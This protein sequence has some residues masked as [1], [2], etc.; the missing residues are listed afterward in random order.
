MEIRTLIED[1]ERRRNS[2]VLVLA[3]SH[4]EIDMAPALYNALSAL[5]PPDGARIS[6][7]DI[8][9][10]CRGGAVTAARR[11]ALMLRQ[12]CD[13]LAFIVPHYC[14]SAGAILVLCADEIIAGPV[15]IF[16]PVDPQLQAPVGHS[17]EGAS[18]VSAEDIRRLPQLC[19]DWFG[20]DDDEA[21]RNA[22]S[23]LAD[24]FFPA[25]LSAF[26]RS[27]QEVRE[28]CEELLSMHMG[29]DEGAIAR[30]I[31]YLLH[32]HHSH[33]FPLTGDDLQKIGLPVVADPELART[34]WAVSQ[35]LSASI[36]GEARTSADGEWIAAGLI[37]R[38]R[39][40]L[41]RRKPDRLS[42]SWDAM[43]TP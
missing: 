8:V 34:A 7:L 32:A 41:Q 22:L 26:Y 20:L 39:S 28:I 23:M 17:G 6:R 12:A 5:R 11:L 42:P 14:Q 38:D 16:S 29:D 25:T 21:R 18:A 33:G 4:L 13:H 15:E 19:H 10:R 40:F 43:A 30:I 36:G 37:T 31:K 1:I 3:A 24:S 9:I 35:Q 2:K 27:T